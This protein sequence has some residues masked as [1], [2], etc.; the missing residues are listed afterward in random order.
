MNLTSYTHYVEHSI[1]RLCV[2]PC[3]FMICC[4]PG[5]K[6]KC[7]CTSRVPNLFVLLCISWFRACTCAKFAC[8]KFCAW[9]HMKPLHAL[10]SIVGQKTHA[11][12]PKL[13]FSTGWPWPLT[14]DLEHRPC[15]RCHQGKSLYQILWPY[16]SRFSHESVHTRTHRHTHR[17]TAP[18]L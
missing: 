8:A 6:L 4:H 7:C 18:F 16:V 15:P 14:Y 13:H 12:T 3:Q 2:K 10:M 1:Y 11:I 5:K 9:T 17:Q